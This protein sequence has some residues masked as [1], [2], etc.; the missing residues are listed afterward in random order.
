MIA[1]LTRHFSQEPAPVPRLAS[2]PFSTSSPNYTP[3]PLPIYTIHPGPKPAIVDTRQ[4]AEDKTEKRGEAMRKQI[5]EKMQSDGFDLFWRE[6]ACE[7]LHFWYALL[8]IEKAWPNGVPDELAEVVK[9]MRH[10]VERATTQNILKKFQEAMETPSKPRV[11]PNTEHI[12]NFVKSYIKRTTAEIV[13]SIACVTSEQ[14]MEML[15]ALNADINEDDRPE[16][17]KRA[18]VL[19]LPLYYAVYVMQASFEE[20]QPYDVMH[21]ART[22][23]DSVDCQLVAE[24]H[25]QYVAVGATEAELL[26]VTSHVRATQ[27]YCMDAVCVVLAKAAW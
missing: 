5:A 10:D 2:S 7:T 17:E 16:P 11:F 4:L 25:S 15:A 8:V 21:F 6:A 19:F 1:N 3:E 18:A 22:I 14:H 9:N 24:M 12:E 26:P 13:G 23:A 20:G 27:M